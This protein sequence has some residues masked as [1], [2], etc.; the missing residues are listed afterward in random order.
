MRQY[1]SVH[2]VGNTVAIVFELIYFNF[3]DKLLLLLV[4]EILIDLPFII[5]LGKCLPHYTFLII[6]D[7]KYKY[8]CLCEIHNLEGL[9]S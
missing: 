9:F 7:M 6:L 3:N 4:G 1:F 5:L 2:C 8:N